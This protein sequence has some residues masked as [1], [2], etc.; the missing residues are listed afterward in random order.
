MK[1]FLGIGG[2]HSLIRSI[3]LRSICE[4]DRKLIRNMGK[5][6]DLLS[7]TGVQGAVLLQVVEEDLA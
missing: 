2:F 5:H 3:Q 6:I 4:V 7:A 1:M